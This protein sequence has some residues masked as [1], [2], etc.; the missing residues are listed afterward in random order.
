MKLIFLTKRPKHTRFLK[1]EDQVQRH[2]TEVKEKVWNLV[3]VK[4]THQVD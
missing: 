2:V 3:R 1:K 4:K